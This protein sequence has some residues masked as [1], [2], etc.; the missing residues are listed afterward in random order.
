MMS[1]IIRQSATGHFR[2][3]AAAELTQLTGEIRQEV[4][5]IVIV[6]LKALHRTSQNK[7]FVKSSVQ[8]SV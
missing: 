2:P 6:I 5:N 8:D 4:R 7:S 3:D 1:L